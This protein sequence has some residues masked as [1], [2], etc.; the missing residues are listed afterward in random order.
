MAARVIGKTEG[1]RL[2]NA[3]GSSWENSVGLKWNYY[4]T[5][6][7]SKG[8]AWWVLMQ[9]KQQFGSNRSRW[10]TFFLVGLLSVSEG[11][12]CG[13]GVLKRC[14]VE[15]CVGLC[16]EKW[17]GK[18]KVVVASQMWGCTNLVVAQQLHQLAGTTVKQQFFFAE[19]QVQNSILGAW[20]DSRFIF[21]RNYL[22]DASLFVIPLR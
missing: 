5:N 1:M 10:F 11:E 12:N 13:R 14:W 15:I 22:V 18:T 21:I 17:L 3:I 2:V 4:D 19:N 20:R 6:F 9:K 8:P 7:G 16:S